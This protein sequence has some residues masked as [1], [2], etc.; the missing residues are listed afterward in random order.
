MEKIKNIV[1]ALPLI[2]ASLLKRFSMYIITKQDREMIPPNPS[3]QKAAIR[4]AR[5]M[6]QIIKIMS[7]KGFKDA[8]GDPSDLFRPS[9][10]DPIP[11]IK[12]NITSRVPVTLA[13]HFSPFKY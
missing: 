6:P 4:P 7:I 5:A 9:T 10:K 2:D 8:N 13:I 1:M 12:V 3:F 11:I